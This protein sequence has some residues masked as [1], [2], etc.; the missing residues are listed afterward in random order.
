MNRANEGVDIDQY[1]NVSRK[2]HVCPDEF[3][4]DAG[5]W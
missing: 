4:V 2:T 1:Q 3:L 5:N